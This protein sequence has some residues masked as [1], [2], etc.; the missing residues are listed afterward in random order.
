MALFRE[1]KLVH[2]VPRHRIEGRT[3]VDVA[4]HLAEALQEHCT[5]AV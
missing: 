2:F 1:G 3:A 4:D 5:P